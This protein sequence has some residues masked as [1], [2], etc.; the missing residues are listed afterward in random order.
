VFI[1]VNF[2]DS[3]PRIRLSF[4][5]ILCAGYRW[6]FLT[7]HLLRRQGLEGSWFET[8]PGKNLMK[9]HV[10]QQLCMVVYAYNSTYRGDPTWKMTKIAVRVMEPDSNVRDLAKEVQVPVF[11]HIT[12]KN[13][14][15]NK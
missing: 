15:I 13:K 6:L 5:K 4:R 14:Q 9:S 8:N 1:C 12:A 11:N 3:A 10:S 2:D 7:S